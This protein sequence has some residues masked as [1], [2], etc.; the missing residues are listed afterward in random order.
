LFGFTA[1]EV[2]EVTCLVEASLV[3]I[4]SEFDG[5]LVIVTM[6]PLI[7][8]FLESDE[9]TPEMLEVKVLKS[10]TRPDVAGDEVVLAGELEH[11]T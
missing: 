6:E 11:C 2:Q 5:S 7:H 8:S 10:P 4:L 9:I 1:F 3:D